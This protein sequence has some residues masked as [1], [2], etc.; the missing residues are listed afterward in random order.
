MKTRTNLLQEEISKLKSQLMEVE[1]NKLNQLEG[2]KVH[3]NRLE[4]RLKVMQ[5]K[6]KDS[7]DMRVHTNILQEENAE[8][9]SQLDVKIKLLESSKGTEEDKL[10][11]KLQEQPENSE[12]FASSLNKKISELKQLEVKQ[13]PLESSEDAKVH[14]EILQDENSKLISQLELIQQQLDTANEERM[15][16]L[17]KYRSTNEEKMWYY[18]KYRELKYKETPDIAIQTDMVCC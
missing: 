15:W 18:K 10:R 13:K 17:K 8:L 2:T 5:K 14:T 11:S 16:Y 12:V 4:E 9:K 3:T 1:Q 6:V 7:E